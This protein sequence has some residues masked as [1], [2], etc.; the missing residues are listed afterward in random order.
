M[1]TVRYLRAN[2]LKMRCEQAHGLL[3]AAA[4]A[5]Y[6]EAREK[7]S[8]V[9]MRQMVTEMSVITKDMKPKLAHVPNDEDGADEL[10]EDELLDEEAEFAGHVEEEETVRKLTFARELR[11][12]R[13]DLEYARLWIGMEGK[14]AL[15]PEEIL[16]GPDPTHTLHEPEEL[17]AL[18]DDNENLKQ[19]TKKSS[20]LEKEVQKL[21][22]QSTIARETL[23]E[24]DK[25]CRDLEYR[26]LRATEEAAEA[27]LRAR[28][29]ERSYLGLDKERK[30]HANE[31][32]RSQK[33]AI[34]MRQALEAAYSDAERL[35]EENQRIR[36]RLIEIQE[37][38]ND[39][40]AARLKR[41]THLSSTVPMLEAERAHCNAAREAR[42]GGFV[43]LLVGVQDLADCEAYRR[44]SGTGPS[45]LMRSE[46][47]LMD[48]VDAARELVVLRS[49]NGRS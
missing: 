17:L 43:R 42:A 22:R 30:M 14:Y 40:D 9:A 29:N 18:E 27:E 7:V 15:E 48:L 35:A 20:T 34:D 10:S 1:V 21:F 45:Q 13:Q 23:E 36:S 12:V 32:V 8:V 38:R 19:L 39:L 24:T 2:C 5:Y 44:M 49:S 3:M 47:D 16:Q 33:E 4:Q 28:K 46:K 6:F 25:T 37:S 11:V 31:A 26:Y 41:E